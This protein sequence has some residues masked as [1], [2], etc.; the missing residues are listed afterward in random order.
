MIAPVA[1]RHCQEVTRSRAGNF[2]Y[3]I[4]LLPPPKRRAMCAV[5]A[6]ARRIDDIGDG[7]S[8]PD[9][10]LRLLLREIFTAAGGTHDDW[11]TY[12]QVMAAE[13]RTAVL[14]SPERLYTNR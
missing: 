6:F 12:D 10:Q 9:E 13:R 11:D 5:Y 3:G 1:Y 8:S 14:I 2:Y 4:R 7:T